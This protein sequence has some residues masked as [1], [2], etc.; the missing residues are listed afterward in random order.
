MFEVNGRPTNNKLHMFELWDA[1]YEHL[2]DRETL[3]IGSGADL[4][5]AGETNTNENDNIDAVEHLNV[6]GGSEDSC[7]AETVIGAYSAWNWWTNI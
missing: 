5:Y 4:H 3:L 1:G 2:L 6:D 7:D